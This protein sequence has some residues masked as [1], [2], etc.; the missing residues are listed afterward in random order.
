MCERI[1]E[2]DERLQTVKASTSQS[3][4][5]A[6]IALQGCLDATNKDWRKCQKQ[7]AALGSCMKAQT[8]GKS[9]VAS[10]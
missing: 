8:A 7:V 5:E 2:G 9:N 10:G 4:L 6:N 1:Q 3:C